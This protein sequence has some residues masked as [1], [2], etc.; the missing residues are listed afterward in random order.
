M[1][2]G[3]VPTLEEL[4]DRLAIQDVLAQHSRGVDRADGAILKSAYWPDATVAYGG[5]NGPA[6]EFCAGLPEGM[7]QYAATQ[8]SIT[9]VAIEL[10]G[11]EARVETY[12]TAYHYRAD[13]EGQDTEM[14]YLGRYLDRMEKRGDVWKI[15]HRQAVM[16]WNQNTD[17]S[18]IL[19]GPP[20]DGLARGGRHPEDPLYEHLG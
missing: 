8:H 4:A 20:F 2:T 5:F 10:R 12:V 16:D 14:T 7:R 11:D 17:A 18:S 15:S 9:N 13:E 6:H 1:E 3:K 19:E